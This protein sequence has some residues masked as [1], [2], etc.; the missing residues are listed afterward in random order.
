MIAASSISGSLIELRCMPGS[1]Q[2]SKKMLST[3]LVAHMTMSA[4]AIA[5]SGCATGHD[6]D[7]ERGA[8]ARCRSL[9]VLGIGAEAADALDIAHRADSH[10]LRAG[11]PAGA[12]DPTEL[13]VLARE[14]F[15]AEPVGGADPHAL[16]DAIGQDRERLAVSD[17]E[18]EHEPDIAAVR[19]AG[20]LTRRCCCLLGQVT[21]SESMRTAPMPNLGMTPS[22]DFR[23]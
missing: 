7:A 23:L 5:S 13:R 20:T 19:R 21:M 1:I 15:D 17:R 2:R 18:Q 3:Q 8:H 22:M 14:I 16:H 6:F 11:L 9:A 10:E 4:P 12:E